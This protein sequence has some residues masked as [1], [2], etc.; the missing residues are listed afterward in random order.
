MELSNLNSLIAEEEENAQ[1]LVL[2]N[3]IPTLIIISCFLVFISIFGLIGNWLVV[4][5]IGRH[6]FK[7]FFKFLESC[8]RIVCHCSRCTKPSES[9]NPNQQRSQCQQDV[10]QQQS[11]HYLHVRLSRASSFAP[12]SQSSNSVS[13]NE[14]KNQGGSLISINNISAL[15]IQQVTETGNDYTKDRKIAKQF[16]FSRRSVMHTDLNSDLLIVLLAINDLVICVV[17]IPTTIFL[18]VWEIRT[19]DI[20]CRLHVILKSFTLTVSA[21]FLVII[22]LDRWLLVCFI[23]CVIMTKRC[24]KRL[25]VGTYILGLLWAIPM[26]LHQGVHTYFKISTVDKLVSSDSDTIIMFHK[27]NDVL[28]INR[29]EL[30]E[31]SSDSLLISSERPLLSYF[32]SQFIDLITSFTNYGYCKSDERFISKK[33][34][35]IYQLSILILFSFIFTCICIFYGYLF[36]FIMIH[37]YRWRTKFGPKI[38]VVEPMSTP[39]TVL[40]HDVVIKQPADKLYSN[41]FRNYNRQRFLSVQINRISSNDNQQ[42]NRLTLSYSDSTIQMNLKSINHH[43]L[44]TK[45]NQNEIHQYKETILHENNNNNNNDQQSKSNK[46]NLFNLYKKSNRSKLPNNRHIR[47]AITFILITV[48]FL[49][50]YLPS[51]LIANRFIWPVSWELSTTTTT[52][53]FSSSDNYNLINITNTFLSNKILENSSTTITKVH[54]NDNIYYSQQLINLT[55][56]NI[57]HM[58]RPYETSKIKIKYHLRRLF[59]FLYFINSAANPLIYF[60][61]NLKFRLQLKHLIHCFSTCFID[62]NY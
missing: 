9:L 40:K 1:K 46:K 10:C 58:H 21:L 11:N 14:L 37:Q 39:Q 24:M 5:T 19:Y 20:I 52:N 56:N 48:S 28:N 61:F 51:L 12:I 8:L 36:L 49:T 2:K 50:S 45:Q 55:D 59:H 35:E 6:I 47:S 3:Y 43:Q 42:P 60:F 22:A 30:N 54:S 27:Q 13:N 16:T 18:I 53:E 33:D 38:N 44:K 17:D 26:G 15:N 41:G 34:Y 29:S 23:P 31:N 32:A 62:Y 7:S 4:H 25:I 57:Q